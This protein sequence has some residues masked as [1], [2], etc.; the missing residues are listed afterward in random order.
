M[1]EGGIFIITPF[2]IMRKELSNAWYSSLKNEY[3]HKWMA[4]AFGSKNKNKELKQFAKD[5][6][7][8]VHTFQGKEASTVILCLAASD[9]R[10]KNGGITWVNSKPNLINVAVTRAKSHFFVIGDQKDWAKGILSSDLQSGYMQ[11]YNNFEE[12]KSAKLIGYDELLQFD[13]KLSATKESFY[14]GA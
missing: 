4:E 8:T 14:F 3:N 2:S 1:I 13:K 5:N 7:G 9:V 11:M 12:V 10:N 6:I